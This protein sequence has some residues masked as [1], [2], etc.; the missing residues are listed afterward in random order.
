[1]LNHKTRLL[2]II[3]MIRLISAALFLI[4]D[5]GG[6]LETGIEVKSGWGS[7]LSWR[8]INLDFDYICALA[9]KR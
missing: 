1:M 2:Q 3:G 6:F 5:L 4:S 9:V 8:L 7:S